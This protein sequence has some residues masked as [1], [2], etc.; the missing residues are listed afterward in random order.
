MSKQ[1]HV[2]IQR[3]YDRKQQRA[4][5]EMMNRKKEVFEKIPSIEEID[6]KIHSLG[7]KYNKMILINQKNADISLKS[8]EN[9]LSALKK[10]RTDLLND[11]NYPSN[12]L[13]PI[14]DCTKCNDT[15][16]IGTGNMTKKCSCYQ[17][18]IINYFYEASNMK[19]I[20][21]ENFDAFVEE[22]YS[23]VV[24]QSK[25]GL[26]VSPRENI[27]YIK[28]ASI[29]FIEDFTNPEAKNLLFFGA[30]GIG[31]TF[32]SNC[33]AK[34]LLEKGFTV[35]YQTAPNLFDIITD[36]KLKSGKENSYDDSNYKYI[37]NVELLIIDDLG[38]ERASSAKYAELLTILNSRRLNNLNKPCKTIIS[39]NLDMKKM[40]EF[41]TERIVSRI[42]GDFEIFKFI[43]DDIRK[44]R[45][46]Q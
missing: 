3:E 34:E 30:T 8:L 13:E 5:G 24:D 36:Y 22:Y 33:I 42:L 43:G 31:K 35:L 27:N 44:L 32:M 1:I 14:Y 10:Q 9:E 15:G 39:T 18:Q 21:K 38:I 41:Y 37:L 6:Y 19:L 46:T 2:L 12:Y 7:V 28:K 23:D 16:F 20:D 40:N 25:Y 4:F 45:K 17:Q 11:N 29:Q 26:S